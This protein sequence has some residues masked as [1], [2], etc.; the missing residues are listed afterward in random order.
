MDEDEV[1]ILDVEAAFAAAL[2]SKSD[3][4]AHARSDAA[5]A[6]VR[7]YN[8]AG[9][10]ALS[11]KAFGACETALKKADVILRRQSLFESQEEVMK[12]KSITFNNLACYFKERRLYKTALRW[13]RKA[14]DEEMQLTSSDSNPAGTYI[15]MCVVHSL[16][17]QHKEAL[18][19]AQTA[20]DMIVTIIEG[21]KKS[22]ALKRQQAASDRTASPL[23][24]TV[25][26]EP[27]GT[28]KMEVVVE[29]EPASDDEIEVVE[30]GSLSHEASTS[31]VEEEV[32]IESAVLP[33]AHHNIAIQLECLG[34]QKQAVRAYRKAYDSAVEIWGEEC[35][36]AQLFR[37][38]MESAEA[39]FM[40]DRK[41]TQMLAQRQAYIATP[42]QST[43]RPYTAEE[44]E[45]GSGI[46]LPDL[47]NLLFPQPPTKLQLTPAAKRHMLLNDIETSGRL[48][49]GPKAAA[50]L[51]AYSI[52][53]VTDATMA[54]ERL[55]TRTYTPRAEAA[56]SAIKIV[57][58]DGDVDTMHEYMRG[59]Y[60]GF[61]STMK[62]GEALQKEARP[63][64][65]RLPSIGPYREE[66]RPG[67]QPVSLTRTKARMRRQFW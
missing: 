9:T 49:V 56:R 64:T 19:D 24:V 58:V 40:A 20:L 65:A 23:S 37:Q 52:N 67:F 15:N 4:R 39:D 18:K 21:K 36:E 62:P 11:K 55:K 61:F 2:A 46:T 14:A 57:A 31:N 22:K 41:P 3:D 10:T 66:V 30:E 53:Q 59:T 28:E 7:A 45:S 5:L 51:S 27:S 1:S 34:R 12:L 25:T 29:S 35:K 50:H 16:M 43:K 44:D 17:G 13:L 60:G 26:D 33:V 63:N 6:L 8:R 54:Y 48:R 47:T 38:R 42:R 32:G